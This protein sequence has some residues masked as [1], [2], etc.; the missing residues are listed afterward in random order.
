MTMKAEPRL[1]PVRRRRPRPSALARLAAVATLL[2]VA[3]VFAWSGSPDCDPVTATRAGRPQK[4]AAPDP[5]REAPTP[6][7]GAPADG[8][9]AVPQGSVGVPVRVVEPAALS[10]VR[11][12]DRVDLLRVERSGGGTTPVATAALVLGMTPADDPITGGLLV[13]LRPAEAEKALS[14]PGRGFAVLLRPG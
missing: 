8:R 9:P 2:V 5:S 7:G 1:D 11:P 13:A 4:S 14:D 10:L 6:D 12:G 3:A